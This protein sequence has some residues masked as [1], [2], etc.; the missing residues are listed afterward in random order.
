MRTR[1]NEIHAT[2]NKSE[3]RDECT[4]R[5]TQRLASGFSVVRYQTH[6]WRGYRTHEWRGYHS[7]DKP[8]TTSMC[9]TPS[10]N[11]VFAA[12]VSHLTTLTMSGLRF[13]RAPRSFHLSHSLF[14]LFLLTSFALVVRWPIRSCYCLSQAT[15]VIINDRCHQWLEQNGHFNL[16]ISIHMTYLLLLCI[17]YCCVRRNTILTIIC[18]NARFEIYDRYAMLFAYNKH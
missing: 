13:R 4:V 10:N 7:H 5:P 11:A 3:L 8:R 16:Y 1:R 2:A 17:C 12:Y 9:G 15:R 6:E 18:K 14:H